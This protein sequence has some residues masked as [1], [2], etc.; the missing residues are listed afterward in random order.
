[1]PLLSSTVMTP[2]FPTRSITSAMSVPICGSAAETVAICAI[3]FLPSTGVAFERMYS[4]TACTPWSMPRRSCIGL[5]PAAR[6]LRP[7]LT[8]ACARTVAVVVPSPATSLVLVAASFRSCAPMFSKGSSSEISLATVTPSW[9][10]VGAPNFLSSAT[11]RP[12]GPRVVLTA[13]ARVSMPFLSERRACSSKTS[14]L[15]MFFQ[16]PLCGENAF[17]SPTLPASELL[18]VLENR[19]DIRL[20][21]H[22]QVLTVELEFRAAVL[23][24]EHAVAFL[25]LQRLAIALVGELARADGDHGSFLRLFLGGIGNDE[26]AR[27]HLFL[28]AGP[29]DH[30]VADGLD[31]AG[32]D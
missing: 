23:G 20:A 1:M 19:Q 22:E 11:L 13:L 18:L 25:D 7:S 17:G 15:A 14:C 10:T 12:L 8:I 27:R 16:F 26:A 5:A 21:Q 28:G 24:E 4:T 9:V 31:L 32:H 30:A 2:S 29:D 3:S 6:F